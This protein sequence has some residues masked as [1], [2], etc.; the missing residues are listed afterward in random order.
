[1][2]NKNSFILIS[3][4]CVIEN[5]TKTLLSSSNQYNL[6]NIKNINCINI[7]KKSGT[8]YIH[9]YMNN[10][11]IIEKRISRM[12]YDDTSKNFIKIQDHEILN[13]INFI[14][15]HIKDFI[16]YDGSIDFDQKSLNDAYFRISKNN[17][18]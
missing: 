11:T 8:S 18:K 16:K 13:C 17:K 14:L 3:N 5:E 2:K 4:S 10:D 6:I 1:M 12:I 7:E 9:L 15:N